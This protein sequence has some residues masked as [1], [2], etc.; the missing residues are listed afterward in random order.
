MGVAPFW[1]AVPENLGVFDFE[2][3]TLKT[4]PPA[5]GFQS[6]ADDFGEE[7]VVAGEAAKASADGPEE[8]DGLLPVLGAGDW[9][10]GR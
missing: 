9:L 1:Q 4:D 3:L 8:G 7:D 6:F 5:G 2:D 10:C